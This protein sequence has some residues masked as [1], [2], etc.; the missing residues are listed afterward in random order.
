MQNQA[1]FF[2]HAKRGQWFGNRAVNI[3]GGRPRGNLQISLYE[4]RS[5]LVHIVL[6]ERRNG[7]NLGIEKLPRPDRSNDRREIKEPASVSARRT[8]AK[9]V[10]SLSNY[11]KRALRK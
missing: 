3:M 2:Q 8:E 7:K 11:I 6:Q 10:L 4:S 1:A 9:D 5:L